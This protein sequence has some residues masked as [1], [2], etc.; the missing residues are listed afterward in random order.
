[1]GTTK[2]FKIGA[3]VLALTALGAGL[4]TYAN[5]DTIAAR[6]TGPVQN[7]SLLA[8]PVQAIT[9]GVDCVTTTCNLYAV[10]GTLGTL[11]VWGYSLTSGGAPLVPGP[12]IVAAATD[13]INITLH[14]QLPLGAGDTSLSFSHAAVGDVTGFGLSAANGAS[15]TYSFAASKM[16]GTSIYEAGPGTN[17]GN[18]QVAMGLSGV[19]VVRPS[20]CATAGKGCVYGGTTAVG[21]DTFDDEALVALNSFDVNFNAAPL[22]YN[23]AKFAPTVHMIN[24]KV[25]PATD[26]IDTQAGHS[27]ALR[28]ANL[29]PVQKT[30]GL[31]GSHQTLIGRDA[32]PILHPQAVVA[33][34]FTAGQ[35]AEA[36]VLVPTSAVAGQRFALYDQGRS[37]AKSVT[38]DA[39][40]ALTFLSVWGVVGN[41]AQPVAVL[42]PLAIQVTGQPAAGD[43]TDG[44]TAVPFS[45][46]SGAA[47]SARFYVDS[48]GNPAVTSPAVAAAG[49]VSGTIP[50]TDLTNLV[51]GSHVLWVQ[52]STNGTDW[53]TPAGVAFT[54]D[55][56]GPV[57]D[58]T[59]ILPTATNGSTVD[60]ASTAPPVAGSGNGDVVIH[61]TADTSLTSSATVT[62][63]RYAIDG[64]CTAAQTGTAMTFDPTPA[65]SPSYAPSQVQAVTA[66]IPAVTVG[67][68][69]EGLHQVNV[70]AMD[71]FN[72][73]PSTSAVLPALPVALCATVPL[74]I[75][76][77]APVVTAGVIEP[78][79]T[80]DGVTPY[81]GNTNFLDSIRFKVTVTDNNSGSPVVHTNVNKVE[82]FLAG[83]TYDAN[84]NPVLLPAG[85]VTGNGFELLAADGLFDSNT[86]DA[87]VYI[88]LEL[89]RSLT[90]GVHD[91]Y[92]HAQDAAGNWGAVS[93]AATLTY[94]PPAP[95]ISSLTI[96]RN[97][98]QTNATIT[99]FATA[100]ARAVK[101]AAFEYSTNDGGTWTTVTLAPANVANVASF[102]ATGVSLSTTQNVLVRAVDNQVPAQTSAPVSLLTIRTGVAP[103]SNRLRFS[104][105]PNGGNLNRVRIQGRA[106][107]FAPL[108]VASFE[109]LVTPAAS[110]GALGWVG[111]PLGGGLG[112]PGA[113]TVP[114]NFFINAGIPA[115]SSVWVRVIDNAGNVGPAV[116]AV[117]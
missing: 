12:T 5:A 105:A 65:S 76:K 3:G 95:M 85:A 93:V 38:S 24:G 45:G 75:D 100:S 28:Y 84:G 42:N 50:V 97:A 114:I 9:A 10:A 1:M 74:V 54:I 31:V 18:R 92:V 25:F 19:I 62:D 33:P 106:N 111:V 71:S 61:S 30:M 15:A 44:A 8:Q 52:L 27:V 11:P 37:L 81:L 48:L 94:A 21:T 55:R 98:V 69:P 49:N 26:V 60:G 68:L 58:G 79:A 115:G 63:A 56:E 103:D 4:V 51:N 107:V 20:T 102:T 32:S 109:Y 90:P 99:A 88:P 78:I 116:K 36:S 14:N 57:M 53:G 87:Y 43:V 70:T 73:W 77:T 83:D 89:V 41:A 7:I 22:T 110:P 40:G 101:I 59:T 47:T 112:G 13:T 39:T 29:S 80:S 23:M 67:A 66:T 82:G 46:T 64:T 35:T 108:D 117:P 6:V 2:R 91:I 34:L 16:V 72:H 96:T 113:N 104:A 86:E 17:T